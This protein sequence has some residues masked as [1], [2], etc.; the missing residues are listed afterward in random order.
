M[1]GR[2]RGESRTDL[3]AVELTPPTNLYAETIEYNIR[4]G[5]PSATREEVVAAAKAASIHDVIL[6]TPLGYN[7]LVGERGV[8][9]SGGE[10]QRLS[11]A[12]AFLKGSQIVI[13]DESTSALDTLT[14]MEV[15]NA[16]KELGVNRTRVT[17]AHRLSTVIDSDK[18]VVLRRGRKVE[19]GT[20]AALLAINGGVFKGM[21]RRQQDK[22]T[23]S[24]LDEAD[25]AVEE[26]ELIT[27]DY[28]EEGEEEKKEGWPSVVHGTDGST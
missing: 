22:K 12:R 4:Y 17:V 26:M 6:R 11:V 8:R 13:E 3:R 21:W 24:I 25:A 19:E 10:R 7:T 14:E 20:S 16:L 27:S 1:N 23:R 9:L 2:E 15:T 28:D 18:I 5:R